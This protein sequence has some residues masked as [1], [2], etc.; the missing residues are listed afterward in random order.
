MMPRDCAVR[1]DKR[2]YAVIEGSDVNYL[3]NVMRMKVGDEIV[4]MD[5]KSKE[6][7]SKILGMDGDLV[8]AELVSERHPKSD[9]TVNVGLAYQCN[10]PTSCASGQTFAVTNNGT[11]TN[12]AANPASGV[13][14]YTTVPL[15]FSTANAEAP[16]SL[17]YSDAGLVTLY[18][19]YFIPLGSGAGSANA[20]LGSS[21]FVAQPR[22]ELAAAAHDVR[23]ARAA[24]E[25]DRVALG[26]GDLADVGVLEA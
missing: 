2:H 9:T 26:E 21:Q 7:T 8:T 16:I 3:K 6:Y 20:M 18:A 25:R 19:R 14:S 24:A 22:D 13:S 10:N 17:T 11:T 23:G 4:V 5:S 1:K 12:I 15:K